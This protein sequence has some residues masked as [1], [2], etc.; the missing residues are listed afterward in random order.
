MDELGKSLRQAVERYNK[1]VGSLE[2]R[3]LPAAR[4]FENLAIAPAGS[5]IDALAPLE[6]EPR[7]L[8]AVEL[9]IPKDEEQAAGS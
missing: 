1:S 3:V 9:L 7:S 8:Q 4:K 2:G 5:S 6:V